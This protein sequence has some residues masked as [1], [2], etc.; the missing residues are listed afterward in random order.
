MHG[1]A[2]RFLSTVQERSMTGPVA[3]PVA[4]MRKESGH[5][6]LLKVSKGTAFAT[7]LLLEILAF[8]FADEAVQENLYGDCGLRGVEAIAMLRHHLVS[9]TAFFKG[10]QMLF[11]QLQEPSHQPG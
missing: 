2:A 6:R 3:D 11:L 4:V 9:T 7:K 10:S 8:S 5:G 1:L